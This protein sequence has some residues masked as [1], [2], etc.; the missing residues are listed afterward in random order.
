MW[1][2]IPSTSRTLLGD[3]RGTSAPHGLS[4]MLASL[5]EGG[6]YGGSAAKVPRSRGSLVAGRWGALG[7]RYRKK[8]CRAVLAKLI[9]RWKST[10]VE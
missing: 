6:W 5:N 9:P 7:A 2:R 8:G 3:S 1:R 4:E 10:V